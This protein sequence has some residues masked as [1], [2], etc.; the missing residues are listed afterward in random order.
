MIFRPTS[1]GENMV[2]LR[3][4]SRISFGGADDRRLSRTIKF[5][6]GGRSGGGVWN[7]GG[8]RITVT[9]AAFVGSN[10]NGD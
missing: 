10:G 3:P 7:R 9:V 1:I 6:S 2:L 5:C 8:S 4:P